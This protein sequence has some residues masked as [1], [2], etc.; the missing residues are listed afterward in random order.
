MKRISCRKCIST[1]LFW[2]VLASP[3]LFR[4]QMP[5]LFIRNDTESM[6]LGFYVILP[7]RPAK[8]G[9]IVAFTPPQELW[10][11]AKERGWTKGERYW[12]KEVAA[13]EG[14]TY[15]ITDTG[16]YVND[17]YVGTIADTDRQGKPLPQLR[18][19]FQ[20][21]PG[22]FLPLATYRPSSFDG[23]YFGELPLTAVHKRVY[24]LFTM[25]LLEV[26]Y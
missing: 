20:V 10:Q 4:Q 26:F 17:H 25:K 23:R 9:D 21:K 3:F 11:M 22:Y 5:G 15:T 14:D 2:L 16:I 1:V 24:P 8:N 19:T 13:V 18:G 7:D 6:P 12:L